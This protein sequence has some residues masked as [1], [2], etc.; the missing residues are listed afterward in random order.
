MLACQ[1]TKRGSLTSSITTLLYRGT[2]EKPVFGV[3]SIFSTAALAENALNQITA[4]GFK[5]LPTPPIILRGA[6]TKRNS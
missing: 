6:A 1:K 3:L 2:L 5:G 4:K